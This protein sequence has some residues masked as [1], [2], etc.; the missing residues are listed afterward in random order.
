MFHTS[1]IFQVEPL[2]PL[3]RAAMSYAN[4]Q[5]RILGCLLFSFLFP[6]ISLLLFCSNKNPGTRVDEWT[7]QTP[8]LVTD[9]SG[10]VSPRFLNVGYR[11]EVQ[12]LLC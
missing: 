8:C 9:F 12:T 3:L 2:R 7:G 11:S 6:A 1:K 5:M 4:M 10:G